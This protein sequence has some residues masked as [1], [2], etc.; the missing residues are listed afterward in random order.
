MTAK[1][2]TAC[3]KR[4]P[5]KSM[6]PTTVKTT[7][8]ADSTRSRHDELHEDSMRKR[9]RTAKLAEAMRKEQGRHCTFHPFRIAASANKN[10]PKKNEEK[11]EAVE[12]R[13]LRKVSLG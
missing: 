2:K 1:V 9:D 8:S 4:L 12:V 6:M 5:E 3:N 11:E 13:L 10:K 7:S